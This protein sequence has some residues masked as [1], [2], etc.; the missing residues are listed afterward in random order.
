MAAN[1]ATQTVGLTTNMVGIYTAPSANNDNR[2]IVLSIFASNK[3][4]SDNSLTCG[5]ADTSTAPT[6]I[7]STAIVAA[8]A[9]AIVIPANTSL[10]LIVNKLILQ[11]GTPEANKPAY[12]Y[13]QA[14]SASAVDVTV[15]AYETGTGV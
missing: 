3:S 4:G 15:S 10:E 2:S 7:T 8:L 1:Y 5:I 12:I 6:G 13:A 11:G 14:A 9:N